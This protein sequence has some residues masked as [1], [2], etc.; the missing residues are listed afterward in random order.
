MALF[1]SSLIL[2]VGHQEECLNYKKWD[3]GEIICPEQ[4]ADDLHM[5]QL[6]PLPQRYLLLY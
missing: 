5:V 4:D 2:L 3:A 6:M 1:A